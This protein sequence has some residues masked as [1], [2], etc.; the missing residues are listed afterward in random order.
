M[1]STNAGKSI[2]SCCDADIHGRICCCCHHIH[3]DRSVT[4]RQQEGSRATQR[5]GTRAAHK[6]GNLQAARGGHHH[7]GQLWV[8]LCLACLATLGHHRR[9]GAASPPSTSITTHSG[10]RDDCFVILSEP[11]S[12]RA[13]LQLIRPPKKYASTAGSRLRPSKPTIKTRLAAD[14]LGSRTSN[15]E[16]SP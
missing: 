8:K 5:D 2:L 11:S 16:S 9:H 10:G 7:I 3:L 13:H 4:R 14:L 15:V 12:D 1:D 6:R